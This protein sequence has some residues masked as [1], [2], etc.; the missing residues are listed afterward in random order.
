MNQERNHDEFVRARA[1]ARARA[2]ARARIHRY[3]IPSSLLIHYRVMSTPLLIHGDV[4][5]YY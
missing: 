5:T 3:F 4:I 2:R 1:T